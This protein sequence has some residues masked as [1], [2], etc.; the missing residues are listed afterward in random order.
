MHR[1]H[2]QALSPWTLGT[3][4]IRFFVLLSCPWLLEGEWHSSCH[5]TALLPSFSLEV[6]TNEKT[7]MLLIPSNEFIA[8]VSSVS[9]SMIGVASDGSGMT[10]FLYF[11]P[12]PV[13]HITFM[14]LDLFLA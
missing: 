4:L 13:I 12:D 9:V 2:P 11:E 1:M 7:Q 3:F 6:H 14:R 8:G 10:T 5:R